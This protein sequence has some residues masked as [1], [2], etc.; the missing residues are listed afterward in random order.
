VCGTI[1]CLILESV[2]NIMENTISFIFC[3]A[4]AMECVVAT[5]QHN[6]SSNTPKFELSPT[7]LRRVQLASYLLLAKWI[8]TSI[9]GVIGAL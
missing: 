9:L 1:V 2:D 3:A 6:S 8:L 4:I 7:C 5:I